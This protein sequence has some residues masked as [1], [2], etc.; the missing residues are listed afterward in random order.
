MAANHALSG[1]EDHR[2]TL[3][4]CEFGLEDSTWKQYQPE[5]RD[6][7]VGGRTCAAASVSILFGQSG[8]AVHAC[9]EKS[10]SV[11]ARQH[12]WLRHCQ[13]GNRVIQRAQQSQ[14]PPQPDVAEIL[15]PTAR[16]IGTPVVPPGGGA[17]EIPGI[18]KTTLPINVAE[19][20]EEALTG[21]D[22]VCALGNAASC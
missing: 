6:D 14:W 9:P 2:R 4:P 17:V 13:R 12:D 19:A 3:R 11:F 1:S 7:S 16:P 18:D 20:V 8:N 22:D 21:A 10:G 15:L 5:F